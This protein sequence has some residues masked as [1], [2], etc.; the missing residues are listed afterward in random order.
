MAALLKKDIIIIGGHL[1]VAPLACFLVERTRLV[2][3]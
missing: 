3:S 2:V 1:V